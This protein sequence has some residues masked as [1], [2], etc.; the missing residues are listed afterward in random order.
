METVNIVKFGGKT[1]E[2]MCMHLECISIINDN[3][4]VI[5]LCVPP[6]GSP[7]LASRRAD[8]TKLV[9]HPVQIGLQA[10]LPGQRKKMVN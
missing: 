10:D 8:L 3:I 1:K 9:G 7:P 4:G 2:K 5:R 6:T